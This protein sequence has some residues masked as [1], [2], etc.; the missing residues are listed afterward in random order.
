L[1]QVS[2][3]NRDQ[4]QFRF[5]A[6]LPKMKRFIPSALLASVVAGSECPS[7]DAEC[8]DAGDDSALLSLR[9]SVRRHQ[10]QIIGE[11]LPCS[12]GECCTPGPNDEGIFQYCS[13]PH[14]RCEYNTHGSGPSQC[15]TP[16]P[17]PAPTSEPEGRECDSAAGDTCC[18]PDTGNMC[19]QHGGDVACPDCGTKSCACPPVMTPFYVD[20]IQSQARIAGEW[21]PC[22]G[23]VC[24]D[25]T[26]HNPFQ[27][28]P[29][30]IRCEYNTAGSS[31][32][33]C[34]DTAP[35]VDPEAPVYCNP[36]LTNPEQLCPGGLDCPDCGSHKCQCPSPEDPTTEAP[37]PT[38]APTTGPTN[39][40]F[41][42]ECDA[43][44]GDRCCNPKTG[45]LCPQHGVDVSCPDCGTESCACPP[46]VTPFASLIESERVYCDP[47]A[48][49]AQ[50]CPDGSA[51][52]KCG[53]EGTE[54]C[55]CPS[56]NG[57]APTP[58]NG[59]T[60]AV[61]VYCN[62]TP[63]DDTETQYCPDGSACPECGTEAC[64]CP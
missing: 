12:G 63:P 52:P 51:C 47:T 27:Y 45:N 30:H 37:A 2:R 61:K 20:L 44:N 38:E 25:P 56:D 34:P 36:L 19:E 57:P 17:T 11:W 3:P 21:E 4:H 14:L 13:D 10:E 35:P 33:Q 50:L 28:C 5:Q 59:P 15:P 62:P 60:P 64:L 7:G 58:D 32:S 22:S 1:A 8:L 39:A 9:A 55:L 31:S 49:P 26:H 53:A 43:A 42:R 6:S 54:A 46:E 23:G 18:N 29:G 40:P 48:S 16:S 41:A 24:C